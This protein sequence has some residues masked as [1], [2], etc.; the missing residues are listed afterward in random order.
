MSLFKL[1]ESGYKGLKASKQSMLKMNKS[2]NQKSAIHKIKCAFDIEEAFLSMVTESVKEHVQ[3]TEFDYAKLE[4]IADKNYK[5]RSLLDEFFKEKRS[6]DLLKIKKDFFVYDFKKIELPKLY[7]QEMQGIVEETYK[8]YLADRNKRLSGLRQLMEESE[9]FT[10]IF[11]I[12]LARSNYPRKNAFEI[13]PKSMS[14]Q[15]DE[16]RKISKH[17]KGVPL[18]NSLLG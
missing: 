2:L 10:N 5:T 6:V 15:F 14:Y 16:E 3:R 1:L 18:L 12:Y 11:C 4:D 9:P 8:Q 17:L 13:L 7:E